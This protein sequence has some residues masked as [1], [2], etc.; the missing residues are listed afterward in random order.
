MEATRGISDSMLFDQVCQTRSLNSIVAGSTFK[1]FDQQYV[2]GNERKGC[3]C[4]RD[5]LLQ[6]LM[7]GVDG[8]IEA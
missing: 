4:V 3:S 6:L 7:K 1:I 8:C 2:C 5:C